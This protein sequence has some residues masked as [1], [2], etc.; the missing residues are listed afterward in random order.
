[1]VPGNIYLNNEEC[2]VYLNIGC[3][4]TEADSGQGEVGP[5]HVVGLAVEAVADPLAVADLEL[6]V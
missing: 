6:Q 3:V 4:S 5:V 1:M 2:S